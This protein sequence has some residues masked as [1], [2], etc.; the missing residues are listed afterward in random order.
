MHTGHLASCKCCFARCKLHATFWPS[1]AG[2]FQFSEVLI[3]VCAALCSPECDDECKAI[4]CAIR[5]GCNVHKLVDAD[6]W[7]GY[8]LYVFSASQEK[9]KELAAIQPE[10]WVEEPQV[11][12]ECPRN[13]WQWP[14]TERRAAAAAACDDIRHTTPRVLL[15]E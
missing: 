14:A 12:W 8:F 7:H 13:T 15:P 11:F 9:T 10:T 5:V 4:K 6:A 1:V 3:S 2:G